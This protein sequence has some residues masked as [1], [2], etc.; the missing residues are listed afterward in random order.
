MSEPRQ[1]LANRG[2]AH[3]R[4]ERVFEGSEPRSRRA[5]PPT[6]SARDHDGDV[7]A[8]ALDELHDMTR[9]HDRSLPGCEMLERGPNRA[10]RHRINRLERL[11][12]EAHP[13]SVK[14]P[15]ASTSFLR[16]PWL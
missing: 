3:D 14:E 5:D 6:R 4:D 9:E 12:E 7:I 16:I 13:G 2:L 1:P 8:H 11:V 15:A 10:R